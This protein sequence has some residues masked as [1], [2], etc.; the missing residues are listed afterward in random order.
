[1]ASSALDVELIAHVIQ[2]AVAPVF[3]LMAVGSVLGILTSRLA[4]IIDRGRRLTEGQPPSSPP[5]SE[6]VEIELAGLERRR[7]LASAAITASS[8]GM[9][10]A[11]V[12]ASL[13]AASNLRTAARASPLASSASPQ[14]SSG[15]AKRGD[16]RWAIF[17]WA[18]AASGRPRASSTDA[19]SAWGWG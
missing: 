16:L 1:M 5:H 11:Y 17:N 6:T 14:V 10:V 15:S 2:L 7:H 9:S 12:E 19:H 3:L 13:A 4:R 8:S 18:M